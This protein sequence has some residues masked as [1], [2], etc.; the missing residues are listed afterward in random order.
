MVYFI[1][2]DVID[3]MLILQE[4]SCMDEFDK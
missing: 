3:I 4:P 2:R 1:Y